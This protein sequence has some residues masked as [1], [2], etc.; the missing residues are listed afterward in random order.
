[1]LVLG[2][3]TRAR[4]APLNVLP[5]CSYGIINGINIEHKLAF[6]FCPISALPRNIT[7]KKI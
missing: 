1:M 5:A 3:R 4:H 7:L 2:R 6:E